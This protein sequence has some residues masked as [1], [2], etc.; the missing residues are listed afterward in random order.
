MVTVRPRKLS[1]CVPNELLCSSVRRSRRR[2]LRIV[3]VFRIEVQTNF[4][5]FFRAVYRDNR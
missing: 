5:Q 4:A 3:Q 1:F 2:A